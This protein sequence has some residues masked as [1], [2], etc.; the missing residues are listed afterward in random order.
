MSVSDHHPS[1]PRPSAKGK[2]KM[3]DPIPDDQETS[4]EPSAA[5]LSNLESVLTQWKTTLSGKFPHRQQSPKDSCYASPGA[6]SSEEQQPRRKNRRARRSLKVRL[7][8]Q[9]A[10]RPVIASQTVFSP[11]PSFPPLLPLPTRTLDHKAPVTS[12]QFLATVEAVRLAISHPTKP[13]LPKLNLSGSSG[14]YFCKAL[15][16]GNVEVVGIFKPK[17]EEPYGAMNPKWTKWFHRVLL[18]PI[19]GGFGRSCLIPNLSYLSEAAAS[20]LDRRLEAYIV[21]HTEV[22]NISSSTFFYSWLDRQAATRKSKPRPLPQ[23]PGSFQLFCNGFEDASTV[24]R[25]H[26]WPGRPLGDTFDPHRRRRPRK[27]FSLYRLLCGQRADVAESDEDS[28]A[29]DDGNEDDKLS[30]PSRPM[31]WYW[32][33]ELMDDF[34]HEMEKLVIL[35]YLMRNT[36][37]GLDNFMIKVCNAN[38][39]S[40]RSRKISATTVGTASSHVG[41][42]TPDA[43]D[44]SR[45][46]HCHVAAI[47]NSLAFPH[48]HPNGWRDYSYGWLWLPISLIGQP[49]SSGTRAHYLRLLTDPSWWAET[50]FELRKLFGT[51]PDFNVAMFE[52]QIALLKGQGWNIVESLRHADEGPLELCR[53]KKALVWDEPM[54][55]PPVVRPQ[56][57]PGSAP[58]SDCGPYPVQEPMRTSTAPTGTAIRPPTSIA[59]SWSAHTAD[60]VLHR[61]PRPVSLAARLAG[62]SEEIDAARGVDVMK[63]MDAMQAWEE[64]EGLN[65]PGT[66]GSYGTFQ[67]FSFETEAEDET[68]EERAPLLNSR[69]PKR[70]GA[71]GFGERVEF[72][73]AQPVFKNC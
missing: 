11:P 7:R 61:P 12:D 20:V 21:P 15:V 32:T 8:N 5:D 49:F 6:F 24:L 62:G 63:Q 73:K 26:P 70:T 19:I 9:Q 51:D 25:T 40:S 71:V 47:D 39:H 56:P 16:D 60:S 59:R 42:G 64:N 68:E 53:R 44:L 45:R 35:D 29:S 34:R 14:S 38:C 30:S 36:D 65:S 1:L 46:P 18:A 22:V 13:L 66:V 72:V 67:P 55:L 17:D 28:I 58:A 23:K 10:R 37:R 52:R 43:E 50:V 33:Q 2:A 31:D 41:G 54:E 27:T 3:V 48:H 4:T 57:V 69:A